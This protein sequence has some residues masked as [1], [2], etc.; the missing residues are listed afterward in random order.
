MRVLGRIRLS[1]VTDATT[2]PE[3]QRADIE[4]WAAAHGHEIVGWAVDLDVGRSVNPLEAPELSTWLNDPEKASSW[5]IIVCWKLDRLA[6]GSIY[7]ADV[8]KWC[9]KNGKTIVSTSESFDLSTWV[10]RMLA[11]LLAGVAEG[12]L[13][14]IRD[15]N[16]S[17]ARH[18]IRSGKYRGGVAPA[19]YRGEKIDG[20]WRLVQD[21][22]IAPAIKEIV[23]RVLDGEPIRRILR[24]FD[25]RGV[26]SPKARA[27]TQAGRGDK[28][29]KWSVTA[30]IRLLRSPTMLGQIVY[31]EA[32][33]GAD[34]QVQRDDKGRKVYGPEI[35]LR[36][37]SGAPVVRCEPLVTRDE[38]DRVGRML[39][40][41][42]GKYGPKRRK[43]PVSPLLR[44]IYCGVC[45]KPG[46][47]QR[48]RYFDYWRCASQQSHQGP[49][50]NRGWRYDE[51]ETFAET[52]LLSDFGDKPMRRREF[53]PGNSNAAELAEI[54]AELADVAALVGTPAF[55]GEAGA[56][57]VRRSEALAARRDT[58]E[59]LPSVEPGY[60][61]VETGQTLREA[62]D[63]WT[64]DERNQ[65]LRKSGVRVI[66]SKLAESGLAV[67]FETLHLEK[68]LAGIDPGLDAAEEYE[69]LTP[70]DPEEAASIPASGGPEADV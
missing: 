10:G 57:L 5:D 32:L 52:L 38:F 33:V 28:G 55:R 65:F 53:V 54:E 44:V 48:G 13:E 7:L 19:G 39:D 60:R 43:N 41:L 6:V 56:I 34:G 59:A 51:A 18:N 25:T 63:A 1:R 61:L 46:Y 9:Q 66:W 22:I 14:A 47:R 11:A 12:E 36:D 30:T 20:E 67:D 16:T 42:S 58:L 3:R 26:P 21:E 70:P 4:R 40:D 69:R 45:G 35:V 64:T 24:D 27:D 17:A 23:R 2:S 37:E 15:R 31:R 68:L 50:A 29:R 62:W 49:C 8:M